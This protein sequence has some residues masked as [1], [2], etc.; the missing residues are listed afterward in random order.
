MHLGEQDKNLVDDTDIISIITIR[1][2]ET[3]LEINKQAEIPVEF[4]SIIKTFIEKN[5]ARNS[6]SNYSV[7]IDFEKD[8]VV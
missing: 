6:S 7:D 1:V 3:Y 8:L 4:L 5:L 2:I